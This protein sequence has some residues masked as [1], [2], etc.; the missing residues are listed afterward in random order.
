VKS[1]T[2]G[3]RVFS[4]GGHFYVEEAG[5][6]DWSGGHPLMPTLARYP[7]REHCLNA[8]QVGQRAFT[9]IELLTVISIIGILSAIT[10][11]VVQGVRERAAVSQA[12]AELAV[13]AQ[14]LEAYKLQYGDYPQ[15]GAAV[16]DQSPFTP[17]GES[18]ASDTDGPGILFNALTGKRGPLA[19]SN[20]VT[21]GRAYVEISRLSFQETKSEALPRPGAVQVANA[22]LDPWGNRYLY[23]NKTGLSWV[24]AGYILLSAGPDGLVAQPTSAGDPQL[25]LSENVDNLYSDR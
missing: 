24:R 8:R 5:E 2:E 3:C 1:L 22:F 11:G 17:S 13:L 19:S 9:L 20:I 12:K 10:F 18:T 14:A 25:T 4:S 7:V 6:L 23:Y 21:N 16:N 15:T